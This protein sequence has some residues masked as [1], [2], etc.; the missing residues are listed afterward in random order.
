MGHLERHLKMAPALGKENA[1]GLGRYQS[2]NLSSTPADSLIGSD[3]AG[4]PERSTPPHPIPNLGSEI[5]GTKGTGRKATKSPKL[6]TVA[7]TAREKLHA[8]MSWVLIAAN[9]S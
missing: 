2:S 6:L 4:G 7:A 1:G 5:W 8:R 3:R 9:W